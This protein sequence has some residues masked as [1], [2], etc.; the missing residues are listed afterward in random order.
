[1]TLATPTSETFVRCLVGTIPGNTPAT[2]EVR[3][4][5]PV[6]YEQINGDGEVEM[7]CNEHVLSAVTLLAGR[8]RCPGPLILQLFDAS[9][10]LGRVCR[11]K[12]HLA[13][14]NLSSTPL[15]MQEQTG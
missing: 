15:I 14:K 12:G 6:S 10:S 1:M 7:E 3:S 11:R 8:Q 9:P 2:F 5:C 13:R 4:V